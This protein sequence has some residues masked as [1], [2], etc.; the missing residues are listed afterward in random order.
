MGTNTMFSPDVRAQ[1]L[2]SD[3]D[4]IFVQLAAYREHD[5]MNTINSLIETADDPQRFTFGICLQWGPEQEHL[6]TY[7]DDKPEYRVHTMHYSEAKGLGLARNITNSL[8]RGERWTLQIDSHMRFLPH[9]DTQMLKEWN[10]VRE[11]CDKPVITT[12]VPPFTPGQPLPEARPSLMSQYEFSYDKLLMSMPW[13]V[14]EWKSLAFPI[15][16][17]TISAHFLFCEGKFIDEVPYDP[18]IYFGGYVEEATLSSRAWTHGWDFYS[19][20]VCYLYHEYTR[21]GR[22][23][24]W[25]DI[26]QESLNRDVLARNKTRQLHGQE[27]HGI[28]LGVY[29]LGTQRTFR[30]WEEFAGF[31]FKNTRLQQYTLEVR[32]PPNPMPWED[33][34]I[35][36][37]HTRVVTIDLDKVKEDCEG[38]MSP[39]RYITLGFENNS[40]M[41]IHR[42]DLSADTHPEVF[43]FRQNTLAV[44]FSSCET[45]KKATMYT[46]FE[47]G[48]FG[49]RQEVQV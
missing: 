23:K 4:K 39:L 11:I 36:K 13:F 38:Q 19:P 40:S 12:Y 46:L 21:V 35:K 24:V 29:G 47:N 2:P 14:P 27:N 15:R 7:W 43:A 48:L 5:L 41:C 37:E 6:L 1:F 32:E 45:P 26:P 30:E 33:G 3:N 20:Y 31:D 42:A 44:T 28:D 18:E 16:A 22:P 10:Q 49:T 34:F 25:E 9:W 17:R 8:W